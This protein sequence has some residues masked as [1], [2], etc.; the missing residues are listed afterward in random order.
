MAV[1]A[2]VAGPGRGR[3]VVLIHGLGGSSHTWDR[4]VPLI[5]PQ[6]RVL[7]LNVTGRDSIERE[8]DDASELIQGP[9]VLVG[10]SRG[11]LV[12]T[13]IAE[14]HPQLVSGLNLICPPWAPGSRT[15]ARRPAERALGVP[16][17][18]HLVWMAASDSQRRRALATA[19]GPGTPVADQFVTDLRTTGRRNLIAASRAIDTYLAQASLAHRLP[20]LGVHV[21]LVFGDCDQRVAQ[22]PTDLFKPHATTIMSGVGHTPPWEVPGRIAE[23]IR[24]TLQSEPEAMSRQESS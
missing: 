21:D 24:S 6:A 13:A 16:G 2:V 20:T 12:A 14:R 3:T 23:L 17:L 5:E 9:A 10:H 1:G 19:F 4:V 22:P 15:S 11:G 7:A 18:G 8:A